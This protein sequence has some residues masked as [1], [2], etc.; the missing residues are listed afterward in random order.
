MSRGGAEVGCKIR[1]KDETA[2]ETRIKMMTDG[3][4]LAEIQD[5]PEFV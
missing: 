2:P 4:L 3:M 1:F 5:D